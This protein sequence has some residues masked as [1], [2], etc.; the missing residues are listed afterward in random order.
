MALAQ[1]R[2]A[3][4]G[5]GAGWSWVNGSR[6]SFYGRMAAEVEEKIAEHRDAL[7][8]IRPKIYFIQSGADGPIKIGRAVNPAQRLRDLQIAHP[9]PLRL[10]AVIDR[11]LLA[12]YLVH[13]RFRQHRLRGEWFRP[14]PEI[15]EYA[16]RLT[17][18]TASLTADRTARPSPTGTA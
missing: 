16:A 8:N 1:S 10:L 17:V 15:L 7:Y 2:C 14:A 11:P 13:G 6:K 12:E 18:L 4:M 3:E 9:E 5:A